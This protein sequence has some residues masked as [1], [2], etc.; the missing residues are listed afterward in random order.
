MPD[1]D[2]IPLM[3]QA[4]VDGRSQIHKLEDLKKKAEKLG[5]SKEDLHQQA[6]DWVEEWHTAC[7][8]KNV[9]KF[10]G[11]IQRK[12]FSFTWRMVTNSGQDGGVIR[13]VIGE[14]GWAYFPGSSMKGAFRRACRFDQTLQLRYC[15]GQDKDGELHP[16]ILRFHGGYPQSD[17]WLDDSLV[18]MI[19]PQED[20]QLNGGERKTAI[21]LSLYQ[22][23]LVFGISSLL[24][25]S[26]EEWGQIWKI[27]EAAL[28][29]GIGS[30]V[31]AGY[32]QINTHGLSN[33]LTIVLCGQGLSSKRID[34]KEEFR[35]NGFKA[36]LRGHTRRLFSGVTDNATAEKLTQQLWGG[37]AD[38]NGAI[39]GLLGVAF[40]APNLDFELYH[41]GKY[42]MPLYD[43]GEALLN[44]L[45]L[46]NKLSKQVFKK[47]RQLSEQDCKNIKIFIIQLVKFS[48]LMGGF[49]KSWRRIDH[50]LFF[51][52]YLNNKP[53][54]GSHWELME[55]S[56]KRYVVTVN[57]LADITTFL[58]GLQ[59][60][61]ARFPLLQEIKGN[62]P[63]GSL[64][65]AWQKGNVEVWGRI[66][67][68]KNDSVA[69]RWFHEPYSFGQ[70]IQRSELTGKMGEIGRIWH[71]MYPR[72]RKEG[73]ELIDRGEYVELLTIF[74]NRSGKEEEVEK[75]V[76]FLKFL[77]DSSDFIQ[78][79]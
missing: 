12:E 20:W 76:N 46:N 26:E 71:R 47:E 5:V 51:P 28:G 72:Y 41:S 32:G 57:Q 31:S 63:Q 35:P 44:I 45:L 14:R 69:I 22:P 4:Q 38:Q 79:W 37:F 77:K 30:R 23:T 13:P 55:E 34:G 74:P 40:S 62:K 19:H 7:D 49:G 50:R 25:L 21:Q 10:G 11:N 70:S 54:I 8:S 9:P 15:G 48:I 60:K 58:N 1:S 6:Y 75:T 24:L 61:V 2:N 42:R 39:V 68:K 33:L 43:T 52:N 17:D 29:K 66:A 78:L 64:R 59:Q 67:E 16:G 56:H 53:M 36:A 65:E 73:E 18:D 3:F 27:W